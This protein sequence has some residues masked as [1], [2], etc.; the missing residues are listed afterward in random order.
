MTKLHELAEL[1]Q[2]V[3]FD[4]IQRSILTSGELK[5]LVNQGVRG[6]TSNPSIFEKAIA[7]STDYDDDMVAL[8]ESG[9]SVVDIYETLAIDDIRHAA[10]ILR[11]LYDETKGLDGYVSLEVS[12]ELAHDVEGT[13]ADA[14]RLRAAVNRPNIFIKVPATPAGIPAITALI[15]E[16]ISINVTLIFGLSQYES[17]MEA[18]LK[19]LET[20]IANG[21]D[22]KKVTSVASLFVSRVD[23]ALDPQ[24]EKLGAHDLCGTIALANAKMCYARFLEVFSGDRWERLSALGARV[25][26]PL[27]ASTGTKNPAYADTLYVDNLIGPNT[28]NTAPPDTIQAFLDHGTV[29]VT[30]GKDLDEAHANLAQLKALGLDLDA[31]TDK[32]LDEG[33]EKFAVAYESLL[34]SIAQKRDKLLE[35][36]AS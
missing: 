32:L 12:P 23:V 29:D 9:K 13:I 28:V 5:Q 8:I 19:G 22:V 16:G 18:Y 6:V 21:G 4:Y 17:V 36:S 7:G 14:R 24:L 2:A 27:W 11:P 10:D 26:R 25:Q 35:K 31:V 34:K 33:V 3:W 30:V 15:G 1:G 20:L